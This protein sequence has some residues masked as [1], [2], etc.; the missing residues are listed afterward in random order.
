MGFVP[1]DEETIQLMYQLCHPSFVETLLDFDDPDYPNGVFKT[2]CDK[3]QV[4]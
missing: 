1:A 2:C 3:K 4:C